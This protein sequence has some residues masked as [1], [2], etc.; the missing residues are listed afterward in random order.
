MIGEVFS[1][2]RFIE[3]ITRLLG[4]GMRVNIDEPGQQPTAIH[5]HFGVGYRVRPQSA[6]IDPQVSVYAFG[7]Y[8]AAYF[9]R[10]SEGNPSFGPRGRPGRH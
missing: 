7:Q 9:K 3:R 4:T 2:H 5:N 1:K 6:L 8:N 10:H